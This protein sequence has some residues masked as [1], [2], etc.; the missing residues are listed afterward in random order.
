MRVTNPE[1]STTLFV[2]QEERQMREK[3]LREAQYSRGLP[4]V[5][6]V[7][8]LTY[9]INHN[10]HTYQVPQAMKGTHTCIYLLVLLT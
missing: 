5:F 2:I 3:F 9:F 8:K 4:F 10:C 1:V 6:A 7:Y